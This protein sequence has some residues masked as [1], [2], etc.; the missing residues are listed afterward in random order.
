MYGIELRFIPHMRYD[1]DSKQKQCLRNAMIK[2]KQ[3][4]ANLVEFKL[5]EFE[6]I[7]L[8]ISNLENKI[9]RKLIIDLKTEGKEKIFIA[10]ERSWQGDLTLWVKR[11]YKAEAE[12]FSAHMAAW[13]VKLHRDSIMAKLDLDI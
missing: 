10:I 8:P 4:L 6:E 2:H 11:K 12:V 3:V 5:I 13:L 1:M 9:I 7:D